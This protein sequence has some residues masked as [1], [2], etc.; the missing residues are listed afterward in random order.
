MR[1]GHTQDDRPPDAGDDDAADLAAVFR[2]MRHPLIILD[3]TLAVERANRAFYQAF[4]VRPD[5]TVGRLLYDLGNGQW[6]IPEL[7]TLLEGIL[8]QQRE[9]TDYRVEHQFDR[10]GHR[11][12]ILNAYRM[13]RPN[14]ED[15]I[16]LAIE[17]VTRRE[18]TLW[19][20]EG[21]KEY[22]EKIIDASRDALLILGWDLRVRGANETFYQTFRADPAEVEGRLVYELGDG[23]WD[24]PEL[25]RLLEDVLPDNNA[26]DDF[27][28][29]HEF[30]G[31]GL[32]TMVLNGR[33]IDHMELILLAIEDRTEARRAAA[34]LRQSER[35][36]R[37]LVDATSS[38]IYRMNP[39]WSVMNELE[40]RGFI[41]DIPCPSCTWSR[42]LV[43]PD[44]RAMVMRVIESAVEK[45]S[46]VELEHRVRKN[47]GSYAWALSRAVPIRSGEGKI[48]EWVAAASDL[49]ERRETLA[50]LS[51]AQ[52]LEAVA[53]L[54]G[55]VAHDFNNLLTVIAGNI[56]LARMKS[57]DPEI[58]RFLE[59]ALSPI[60]LGKGLVKRLLVWSGQAETHPRALNL[61]T[62]V[63]EGRALLDLWL[64]KR[65]TLADHLADDLWPIHADPLDIDSILLNLT[66]NARD[67]LPDGGDIRLATENVTIPSP[68]PVR[69]AKAGDY[70]CLTVS[71]T[72]IGMPA[73]VRQKIFKPFF[74]TKEHGTGLGLFS[75]HNK[76]QELGGFMEVES[77][78]GNGTTLRLY[79]PRY[80][81]SGP[82]E[83]PAAA[84]DAGLDRTASGVTVLLVEDQD[85][86][87]ETVRLQ[88][89]ALG[90]EVIAVEDANQ[91]LEVI[92]SD[93]GIGLVLSDVVLSGR[94]NGRELAKR[95]RHRWP[96][97]PVLLTTGYTSEFASGTEADPENGFAILSKPFRLRELG[98]ALKDALGRTAAT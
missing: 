36:L 72:G 44:D 9:V 67:A 86:V 37:A 25:R 55:A 15:R 38:S 51:H 26:F 71:D 18:R 10:I 46:T 54:A 14:G 23:Q 16:L 69:G 40:G 13:R 80:D 21:Q 62:Q 7:R 59:A 79:F 48:V 61:N 93:G 73:E 11:A 63:R 65:V 42:D 52:R 47:D 30:A 12:M 56:E 4:D 97:M 41:K 89:E 70:V 76:L 68:D 34:A 45:G 94:I 33:W 84:A 78:E 95:I 98:R 88:L 53:R 66:H 27:V 6:R 22:A 85:R 83:M 5:E 60:E 8:S 19:E 90:Y 92:E 91:A 82:G 50:S 1:R 75:V 28:V 96:D 20:L 17:D 35:R 24:I 58:G 87:R 57:A 64:D 81:A 39:D 74:T 29:E 31:I 3:G 77:E 32:R 2:T 43:H 49:T